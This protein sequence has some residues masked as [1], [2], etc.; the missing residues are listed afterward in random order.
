MALSFSRHLWEHAL[1]THPDPPPG[2]VLAAGG[3]ALTCVVHRVA[4]STLRC[5]SVMAHEAGHVLA[6]LLCG[7]RVV[8]V[9]LETDN[10]GTTSHR[11][12]GRIRGLLISAAGYPAPS[13]AGIGGA[14]LLRAGHVTAALWGVTALMLLLLTTI[15]NVFGV[16]II[17][18]ASGVLAAVSW[19]GR[20]EVQA[21]AAYLVVWFLLIA[22][23]RHVV[24]LFIRHLL[25]NSSSDAA[26]L[27][28]STGIP[29][30]V[31][32]AV[33]GLISIAMAWL[34]ATWL[35]EYV[36]VFA[37]WKPPSSPR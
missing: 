16:V 26:N 1:A 13:L 7:H 5:Y 10:S 28:T 11:G 8:A 35:L 27:A 19:Q 23:I 15:R 22:A 30:P 33:F 34:G 14:A 24:E 31:W 6:A 37:T 2:L 9:R 3:V 4:W 25:G 21:F 29:W 32:V 17:L 12:K 20:M 36:D 18:F